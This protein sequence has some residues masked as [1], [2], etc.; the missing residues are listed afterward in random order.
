MRVGG[1]GDSDLSKADPLGTG[2]LLVEHGAHH[3]SLHQRR[4]VSETHREAFASD[5]KLS[6]RG[7]GVL[8]GCRL[9]SVLSSAPQNDD[10]STELVGRMPHTDASSCLQSRRAYAVKFAMEGGGKH[11]HRSPDH[12]EP[13]PK[14]GHE[15]AGVAL[16]AASSM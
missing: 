16:E 2:H 10:C 11:L 5:D 9:C 7:F 4:R 1:G 14:K 13:L 15:V 8:R 12:I 6:F 3:N